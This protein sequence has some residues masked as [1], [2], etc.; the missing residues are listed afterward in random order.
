MKKAFLVAVVVLLVLIGLP[1][2]MPGMTAAHCDDCGPALAG[3]GACLVVVLV[4]LLALTALRAESVR[5][6][7]RVAPGLLRSAAFDPPPQLA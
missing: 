6:Q 3:G 1:M 7:R 5:T 2:L 4:A